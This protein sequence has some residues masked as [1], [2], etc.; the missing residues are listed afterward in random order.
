MAND[1]VKENP[2]MG[3]TYADFFSD[4]LRELGIAP[5]TGAL[6]ALQA[7]AHLEG[8]NDRY[9]P[10]NSVV[11]SGDSTSFNSVGVQDY[12]NFDNGVA[13]TV[14]L[15]QGQHWDNVRSALKTGNEQTVLGAFQQAYTWDPGVQ[16]PT[17]F[18][19]AHDLSQPVGPIGPSA[20]AQFTS[21][22][23]QQGPVPGNN[24][25]SNTVNSILGVATTGGTL[26]ELLPKII[27]FFEKILWIF[28]IDHFMKFM[29]Y[30]WGTVLVVGGL[31]VIAFAVGKNEEATS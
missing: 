17:N 4:V 2:S 6:S 14:S 25:V 27:T 19:V 15:L 9:N 20:N 18:P 29:L 16:F 7:V 11:Q 10:L 21:A 13:G 1:P 31:I 3:N 8:Y 24:P 28:N 23:F 12:K 26:A 30:T 22:Q 5:T